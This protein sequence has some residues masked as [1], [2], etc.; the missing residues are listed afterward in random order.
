MIAAMGGAMFVKQRIAMI[1]WAE[2]HVH[3]F[4]D[5]AV[6]VLGALFSG[7]HHRWRRGMESRSDWRG[8]VWARTDAGCT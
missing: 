7:R 4:E 5:R 8:C 6:I 2:D 1:E 3:F